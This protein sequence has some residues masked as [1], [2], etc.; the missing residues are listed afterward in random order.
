[1]KAVMHLIALKVKNLAV[2][3]SFYE[4]GLG[5]PLSSTFISEKVLL[6]KTTGSILEL[7]EDQSNPLDQESIQPLSRI[8]L[9]HNVDSPE[10][11]PIILNKVAQHGAKIIEPYKRTE[12]GGYNARFSDPDGYVWALNYWS[13]WRYKKDETLLI[14]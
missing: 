5:L 13:T 9:T 14:D 4:L 2:S 11:I 8:V 10:Q 1:M 3:R 7:Y 6:F 12:W